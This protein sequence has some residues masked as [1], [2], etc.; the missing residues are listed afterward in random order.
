LNPEPEKGY[1]EVAITMSLSCPHCKADL[2]EDVG[3]E[4]RFCPQC[5]AQIS[6]MTTN[7][8]ANIRTIPPDLSADVES[9]AGEKDAADENEESKSFV[10]QTQAPEVSYHRKPPL[11]IRV[12]PGPPPPSFYRVTSADQYLNSAPLEQK[13]TDK[14]RSVTVL[15]ILILAVLIMLAGGI[16]FTFWF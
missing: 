1:I 9:S 4:Y 8:H 11:E 3:L 16:Y 10:N 2:P 7:D 12:P 15:W 13:R 5:G 6:V 14:R